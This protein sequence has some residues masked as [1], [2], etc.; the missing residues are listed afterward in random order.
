MK[1]KQTAPFLRTREGHKLLLKMKLTFIIVLTC[2]MQV[3]AT[4]YSQATKL[5]LSVQNKQVVDV[6]R[7]I[8]DKSDFRFFYQREQIDVTRKVD[9]NVTNKTVETVLDE[10]FVNT[11]VSYKVMKD[12]LIIIT[13]SGTKSGLSISTQQQKSVSGKVTDSS[14]NGLPGVSVVLKGTTIGTITDSDGNFSIINL[15][16]ES[17]LQF[18]FIGMKPQEVVVGDKSSINVSLQDDAIGIEEVVAVGY[19]VQ[20]KSH[21]TGSISTVDS[22]ELTKIPATNTSSL[23]A[24]RLPGLNVKSSSGQPGRDE[25]NISIRGFGNALIIVDGVPRDFQQLDPNE[26]ESVSVLKDASAAVYGARAGNGVILVTT[27]KGSR[28]SKPKINYSGNY[29]LQR[30]TFMQKIADAPGYASYYQQAEKLA[31][32]NTD[33]LKYSDQDIEKFRQGT[34]PEFQGADWQDLVF[35]DW[36]PMQQHNVNITGGTDKVNYFVSVGNLNQKSLLE[37]GAG[38]Y[39]RYN[40]SSNVDV[41]ITPKLKAG[42]NIKWRQEDRDDPNS[43]DGDASEYYRI[44]RYLLIAKPTVGPIPGEPDKMAYVSSAYENPLA[45]SRQDIAGFSKDNRKQFDMILTMDYEL[46]ISGMTVNGKLYSKSYDRLNRSLRKPYTTYTH[47]YAT[48]ENIPVSSLNQN[49]V[50]VSDWKYSQLTTQLS[51]GY[52]KEI[53]DHTISAILL[54]EYYY[55]DKYQFGG[56]RTDL[57]SLEIPYLFSG[58][59]T[60][61]NYDIPDETGRKSVVGRINYSYKNKY[62][63]EVLFRADASAQYPK[64]TR[65]GYFPGVSLGWRM[66]EESFLKDSPILNYLKL[67]TSYASLGYDAISNFDY[68]TGYELQNGMAYKYGFGDQ[69]NQSTLQSIGLPNPNITWEKMDI[70]NVGA[71]ATFWNGLLGVE[72]DAFYRLRTGLLQSRI[73]TLPDEFGADLPKE[74]LGERNNRGFELVLNHTNKIGE[75]TYSISGNLTWTREKFVHEEEREFDLTDPDDERLNKKTGEWVNRTFG[76]ITDGFY[77]TQ[78]EIDND[79]LTYPEFGEAK[80]GDIKYVDMNNDQIIN[81]RDKQVIGRGNTPELYFGLNMDFKY[82]SFDLSML[83]QGAANYD[84]L[85]S[86]MNISP[87]LSIGFIPFDYQ[88]QHAWN[89]ANPDAA[90]LPAPSLGGTNTHNAQPADIYL[91]KGRYLR[92]KTLNLGYTFPKSVI[93]RANIQNLR[94]YLSGYNLFTLKSNDIFDFDPESNAGDSYATYPVQKIIT[95]GV[96]V[97]L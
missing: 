77:N 36:A 96:N 86:D 16:G 15:T 18:S 94:V 6:L 61:T 42:L 67:R 44:F 23:L 68:L 82:R 20:K 41:N 69:M 65:W 11:G 7:E 24:G 85:F 40:I 76:Y 21:I 71:D 12:N 1:K 4:V 28:D 10:L 26:I 95:L 50:S 32:V 78:E 60:Q 13:P 37:S 74:N 73:A 19:G 9:L 17:V 29:S 39:N 55:E 56:Q 84:V 5:S 52:N 30:P 53:K 81:Y 63:A 72:F 31:G 35:K 57:V 70:Y 8:E 83:W 66:S 49:L 80:I 75:L 93:Q 59:G 62:L 64:D 87:N 27:K 25:A 92:M 79:G 89:S 43:L 33:N 47:D 22:K 2:L 51:V 90:R 3:S 38:T 48:G 97:T 46:P 34:E 88:V 54:S 14:G 45:Y 91:R 58:N